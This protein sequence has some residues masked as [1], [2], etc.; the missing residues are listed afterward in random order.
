MRQT[1][2]MRSH[3]VPTLGL[4]LLAL[5]LTLASCASSPLA[6]S[7][8]AVEPT[9]ESIPNTPTPTSTTTPADPVDGFPIVVRFAL[10]PQTTDE[11]GAT[12]P[13]ERSILI[14]PGRG[15]T[16]DFV[17]ASIELWLTGPNADER[18]QGLVGPLD[19]TILDP[20]CAQSFDFLLAGTS[21]LNRLLIVTL[22]GPAGTAGIGADARILASF[23]ATTAEIP[24]IHRSVLLSAD[25]KSCFGDASDEPGLRCLLPNFDWPPVPDN[26]PDAERPPT[27]TLLEVTNVGPNDPD[28]GL[29]LH[30]APGAA[31]PQAGVAT[32]V[33]RGFAATLR[34]TVV[35]DGGV[36]WE[37]LERPD[38]DALVWA[39]AAFL[40]AEQPS[41][42]LDTPCDDFQI[43][44]NGYSTSG[45]TRGRVEPPRHDH[46]AGLSVDET[47]PYCTV[48]TIEMGEGWNPQ[49]PLQPESRT[50][51]NLESAI[52]VMTLDDPTTGYYGVQFH[53]SD[54]GT[55][56]GVAMT[57]INPDALFEDQF[58][59]FGD[60]SEPGAVFVSSTSDPSAGQVTVLTGSTVIPRVA[61]FNHPARIVLAIT[62]APLD[63][64]IQLLR[65]GDDPSVVVRHLEQ[66]APDAIQVSGW[67]IAFEA[68]AE[69]SVVDADGNVVAPPRGVMMGNPGVAWAPF[70]ITID[71]LAPGTHEL[72]VDT[73]SECESS[74]VSLM[75][76]ID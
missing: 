38:N 9:P 73:C 2:T 23:E 60:G 59:A 62:T 55:Y 58:V 42:L 69:V 31:A 24:A 33:T 26:C 27:N 36:W 46:I 40:Q 34:C 4:P 61:E 28:G 39:N 13:V 11:F 37:V 21:L 12:A 57:G 22:C 65:Q 17:D 45:S 15:A 3:G 67:G 50:S 63:D 25:G 14:E 35:D 44:A 6:E 48:V 66:I 30:T 53:T 71:G 5:M 64:P 75:F 10:D 52:K 1:G 68:Q 29:V 76:T 20:S 18:A 72:V 32:W 19:E 7:P 51:S 41:P 8:P 43:E 70:D 49:P 54:R 16:N 56:G 47:N 74:T